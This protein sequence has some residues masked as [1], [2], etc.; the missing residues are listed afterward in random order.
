MDLFITQDVEGKVSII[1]RGL[2]KAILLK[3]VQPVEI[4]KALQLYD[5]LRSHI[6]ILTEELASSPS[7]QLRFLL[8]EF[9]RIRDE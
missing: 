6:L 2:T 8:E 3:E 1:E 7:T 9:I 4:L 5:N